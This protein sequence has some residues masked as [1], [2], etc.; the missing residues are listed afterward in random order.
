[1]FTGIVEGMGQVSSIAPVGGAYRLVADVGALAEGVKEG[2]SVSIDG[3]CLTAVAVRPP[4]LEFD[5]VR[6]T[7]ERT[8]FASVRVGDRVNVERSMR[9]DGRFHGHFVQ[10]HVDGTGRVVEKR[11][12][13]GG[14]TKVTV[15]LAASLADQIIQKGSIAVSGIS[16][17]ITDVTA[18]TF[19]FVVIPHTLQVTTL[20][21]KQVGSL[22][23]VE[24]DVL[25]K[26][27]RK[28]LAAQLRGDAP[29]QE[30]DKP[31]SVVL[32]SSDALGLTFEDLR[33]YGLG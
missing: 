30:G 16:L 25:G 5:V 29:K 19:S 18:T 33:R 11:P 12:D 23:N 1:M 26:W 31:S 22:V 24:V 6:E 2:D 14:Q 28:L 4:R 15:E 9:A 17:T 13:G 27:I 7:V 10:G 21:Q 8:A 20:G 32:P 3:T